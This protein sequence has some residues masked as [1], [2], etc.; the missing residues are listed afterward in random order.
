MIGQ[1]MP[2]FPKLLRGTMPVENHRQRILI[3]VPTVLYSVATV[4]VA[5]RFRSRHIKGVGS[6]TDDYLCVVALV[7]SPQLYPCG[8]GKQFADHTPPR[9][10]VTPSTQRSSP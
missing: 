3:A 7:S 5:L 8:P 2:G 10:L 6:L 1:D 9:S 4:A